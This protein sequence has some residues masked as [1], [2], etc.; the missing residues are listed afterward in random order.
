MHSLLLSDSVCLA[1]AFLGTLISGTTI[2]E[3]TGATMSD[4]E[5]DLPLDYALDQN[6][7]DAH[8]MM[9]FGP[10]I[11]TEFERSLMDRVRHELKLEFKQVSFTIRNY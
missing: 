6:E 7:G 10:S 1:E 3:G 4:D 5:E 8:E 11:P 2:G 9:G